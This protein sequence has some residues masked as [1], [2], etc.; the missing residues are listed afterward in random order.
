MSNGYVDLRSIHN[1]SF[2]KSMITIKLG[3]RSINLFHFSTLSVKS[4]L[5][6]SKYSRFND[7]EV[8]QIDLV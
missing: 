1:L 5:D 3:I 6:L 2:L 4:Y 8:E 7:F